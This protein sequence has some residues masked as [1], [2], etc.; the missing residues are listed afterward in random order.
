M[1]PS[2]PHLEV[3]LFTFIPQHIPTHG[4]GYDDGAEDAEVAAQAAFFSVRLVCRAFNIVFKLHPALPDKIILGRTFGTEQLLNLLKMMHNIT[5]LT[6]V[7]AVC[8]PQYTE[9]TLARLLK[10]TQLSCVMAASARP[11][12]LRI[13]SAFKFLKV[14]VLRRPEPSVWNLSA[15]QHLSSLRR[16]QLEAGTFDCFPAALALKRL[17]LLEA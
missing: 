6:H 16:L 15:L 3:H 10:T 12:T 7:R 9:A 14:C 17:T 5:G 13:L 1:R 11:P 4:P 8:S 2:Q